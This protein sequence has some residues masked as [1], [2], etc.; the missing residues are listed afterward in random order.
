MDEVF[1]VR[2]PFLLSECTVEV[3]YRYKEFEDR[4]MKVHSLEG[5]NREI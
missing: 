2:N 3:R 4:L 5:S 1:I